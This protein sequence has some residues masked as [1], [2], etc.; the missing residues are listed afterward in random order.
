MDSINCFVHSIGINKSRM[1]GPLFSIEDL[2]RQL[3]EYSCRFR[4]GSEQPHWLELGDI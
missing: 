3:E 4:R 1:S 2:N